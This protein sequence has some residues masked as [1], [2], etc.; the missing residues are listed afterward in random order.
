MNILKKETPKFNQQK[1]NKNWLK[2]TIFHSS[3][4]CRFIKKDFAYYMAIINYSDIHALYHKEKQIL[5][6]KPKKYEK[7]IFIL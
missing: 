4:L 6:K 1:F 5:S 7:N 2:Q 3:L